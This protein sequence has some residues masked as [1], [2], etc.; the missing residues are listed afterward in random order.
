MMPVLQVV[1]RIL[2][3]VLV[4]GMTGTAVELLLLE[5]VED[6]IQIVPLVVIGLALAAL[7]WHVFRASRTSLFVVQ[8]VMSLFLAAGVAGIFYHVRANLEFQ[9]EFDPTLRG[10]ALLWQALR[11]KVPPPLAPGVLVQFALIGL[12]YTYRQRGELT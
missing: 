7:G 6:R 12:A 1:R 8:M 10:R 3:A 11:A 4:I 5:H 9:R 2:L